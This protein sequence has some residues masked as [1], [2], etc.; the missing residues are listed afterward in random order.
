MVPTLVEPETTSL[1]VTDKLM[2][3]S[4]IAAKVTA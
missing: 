2:F 3:M 4:D 1:L